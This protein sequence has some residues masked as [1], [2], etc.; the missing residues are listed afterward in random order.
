MA[1]NA[2]DPLYAHYKK[3]RNQLRRFE[4]GSVIQHFVDAL[5]RAHTGGVDVLKYYQPWNILLAIKWTFQELD[6]LSHRRPH[7]SLN[8][9][10]KILNILHELEGDVPLPSQIGN[11]MLFMRRMAFQQFWR[12]P[13][14]GSALARQ[15]ALFGE[16]PPGHQ[17]NTQFLNAT[18]VTITEFLDLAFA[19]L[20]LVITDNPPRAVGRADFA[21]IEPRLKPRS[22]D[23]FL[24]QLSRT[25][26]ELH[27]WL[28]EPTIREASV[29]D[30]LVLP[31][32]LI[33]APLLNANGLYLVYYPPLVF[34]A[35]EES[36]YRTLRSADPAAFMQKFGP[37]FERYI[38]RCLTDTGLSFTAEAELRQMLPCGKCVD[39]LIVEDGCNIL[40]DAK[41]VEMSPLGRVSYQAEVVYRA[42]KESA[43][44]A[45]V[46][47]METAQRITASPPDSPWGRSEHFMLVVTFEQLNLGCSSYLASTLGDSLTSNLSRQFGATLPFPLENVFFLSVSEFERMLECV[48]A[49]ATT[50]LKV[51]KHAKQDDASPQTQKFHF[52]QHL[53]SLCAPADRL[54][55]IEASLD[56]IQ[57]RCIARLPPEMLKVQSEDVRS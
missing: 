45:V 32:P 27:D 54:P 42:M 9:V 43:M 48:R 6:G 25:P 50:L 52:G 16:L 3:A 37:L 18:G 14:D 4:P 15:E 46:Q 1:T 57:K 44:K 41:G 11:I 33:R 51:L 30:Q 24:Q 28:N 20:A 40:I 13:P 22:L 12:H 39:F 23:G 49:G 35:L 17:F 10:H 56:R 29:S 38:N 36:I 2:P 7:A 31:N 26:Q 34:R 19:L 8:D 5:Y 21:N 47:G 55:F 53:E